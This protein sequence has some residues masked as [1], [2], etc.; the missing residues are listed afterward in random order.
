MP[1]IYRFISTYMYTC[2]VCHPPAVTIYGNNYHLHNFAIAGC[3]GLRL[4]LDIR[5]TKCAQSAFRDLQCILYCNYKLCNLS[6]KANNTLKGTPRAKK[7]GRFN[8]A[9]V[10]MNRHIFHTL[11]RG[12]VAWV[13]GYKVRTFTPLNLQTN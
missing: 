1:S 6:P 9:V 8:L 7:I 2:H 4:V 13:Q 5:I 12:E 10:G 11:F 3:T